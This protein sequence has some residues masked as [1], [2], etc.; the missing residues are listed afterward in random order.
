MRKIL[1]VLLG[2]VV[3]AG[4]AACVVAYNAVRRLGPEEL[5]KRI[6]AA[7]KEQTGLDLVSKHLTTTISYHVIITLDSARLLDGNETVARFGQIILTCGYRT[8]L[9]HGGLPF[10]AV[11]LDRPTVVLPLRSITPGPMPVLDPA[12]VRELRRMLVRLSNVTRRVSMSEATLEDRVGRTLLDDAA[13]RATHSNSASSW[14]VRLEGLFRGVALPSFKFGASLMMAPEM[15]GPEVPFARGSLWFWDV[16][17]QNF[18]SKALDLKGDVKGNLTFLVR[19]D[20]T[21][22]GQSLARVSGFQSSVPF[23]AGPVRVSD[24]MVSGR[25]THSLSG[26]DLGRF[27]LSAEGRELL[28]GSASVRPLP[29]DNLQI[30]VQLSPL[31]LGAQQLKALGLRLRGLPGWSPDYAQM[32]SAGRISI[33][34]LSLDTTLKHLEAPS[35][36]TLLQEAALKASLDGLAFNAPDVPPIA[37]LDGRIDYAGGLVRLTQSHASLGTSTISEISLSCDLGGKGAGLPCQARLAG[38]FDLGELYALRKRVPGSTAGP[39]RRVDSLSG[40]AQAKIEAHGELNAS[41]TDP[42]DYR[43]VLHP[44]SVVLGLISEPSEFRLFGGAVIASPG[45]IVIDKLEL[46]PRH[47]SMK[48]SGNIV[49]TGPGNWQVT[50]L[51][52]D[53]HQINAEEWLPRLI[54]MDTMQVHAPASGKIAI[55]QVNDKEGRR[56]RVDGSLALG[57]GQI[58]FAFLRSPVILIDPATVTI[59]EQGGNLA[60]KSGRLEGSPLDMTVSIE[61]VGKPLIRI[62]AQTQR[63]DLETIAAVRLP[64]SPKTPIKIDNTPFEGHIAAHEANLAHLQMRELKASFKRDAE[65]W[66]VFDINADAMGGHLTMD[67]TGR[68]RDDWVHI[69]TAANNVDMVALQALGGDPTVVTGRLFGSADLWADTNGDF[70]DT[71]TGSIS[72]TVKDGLLLKFKMLSRMLSL[73][74]VSAWLDASVPDPRVNGVPFKTIT[75]HFIG[76]RGDFET[77]DFLLDGPVMKITAAGR[78]NVARSGINMMIGMRPFQLLDTVFNKIPL[79]GG[80]LAQSQSG[81]VSAY[82]HVQGPVGD[83]TVLPAPITSISHLL[84]KTLAIPINLLVPET[85]K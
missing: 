24:L 82:F 38:D 25:L 10:L 35:A 55:A 70:F 18:T 78:V 66:R 4:A 15:D 39:L 2:V 52:L 64:W 58:R 85:I 32:V 57:P 79:I 81:I 12:T 83:P 75:A 71:L 63:L 29:P 56:Y 3:V 33:D 19:N 84:I 1:F 60:I 26:L 16:Q 34:H 49:K 62:E 37:E 45:R 5:N 77:S 30:R 9:F 73:V 23:I 53:L 46:S 27:A 6:T 51:D 50:N 41:A 48:A 7:V 69:I 47:G 20:G 44:R 42:P 11:S 67:L 76:E 40:R 80:R 13:V 59:E 54:A 22:R 61:D 14:R 74:D 36:R 72:T 21:V 68:R 43:A 17:L 65:N 28:S 8:L 31:N